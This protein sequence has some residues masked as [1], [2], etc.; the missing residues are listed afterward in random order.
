M[1]ILIGILILSLL[2]FVHELGHFLFAKRAGV[3]VETFSIGFGPKLISRRIGETEYC[4]SAIL[5]GGYVKMTGQDDMGNKNER[6]EDSGDYRNKTIWQRIQIAFAGP[7]FNYLLALLALTLLYTIGIREAP[8][9]APVVGHVADSSRALAAGFKVGDTL[10]QVNNRAIKDWESVMMDVALSPE[11][12]IIIEVGRGEGRRTLTLIPEAIGREQIGTSGLSQSEPV[13]L[14]DISPASSA[15]EAGLK[16]EDT[17]LAV[18]AQPIPGWNFLVERIAEAESSSVT[19]SVGRA[20]GRREV[21]LRP[22]Y[23]AEHKRYLI[24]IQRGMQL[25]KHRYA[26]PEAFTKAVEHT[27]DDALMIWRSLKALVTTQVSIKGMAGPVGIVHITGQMAR[28]GA[29]LFLLFLAMI[30]VNLAVVNLFP[31]LVITD[32]GVIFFLLIEA[33][34][35]KPLTERVQLRIQQ[36][37]IFGVIALF[38]LLTWNDIFRLMGER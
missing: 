34:R 29:D 7:L 27:A 15:M 5:F 31:F 18:N 16:R 21:T 8:E 37:A 38:L 12:A 9:N 19:L 35:G 23:S 26:L 32:G 6:S 1:G 4:I 28:G 25:V 36:T 33:L 10:I 20:E 22:R 11:K 2:V 14:G 3:R 24:G 13:V 30:S 17:L